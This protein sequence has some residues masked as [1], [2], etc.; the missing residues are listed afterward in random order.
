V[1]K[2]RVTYNGTLIAIDI[3]R[4][5]ECGGGKMMGDREERKNEREPSSENYIHLLLIRIVKLGFFK[6]FLFIFYLFISFFF[7]SLRTD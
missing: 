6:I 2:D 1:E 4:L 5:N 3:I 7:L